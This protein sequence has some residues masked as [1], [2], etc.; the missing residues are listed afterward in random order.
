MESGKKNKQ[1][2]QTRWCGELRVVRKERNVLFKGHMDCTSFGR[3]S[4][5]QHC[6][7]QQENCPQPNPSVEIKPQESKAR[8][9]RE[10]TRERERKGEREVSLRIEVKLSNCDI[11]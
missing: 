2:R 4:G 7:F 9:R 1:T 8:K 11:Q 5:N 3:E 6:K 10:K